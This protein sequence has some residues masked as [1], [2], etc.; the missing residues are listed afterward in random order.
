MD[1]EGQSSLLNA[2]EG[3]P[4]G[5]LPGVSFA[6]FSRSLSSGDIFAF[7]SDGVSEARNK[8]TEEYS[9]ERLQAVIAEFRQ[10]TAEG[11]LE[12]TEEDLNKF[13]GKAPQHD[14]ITLIIAKI[15]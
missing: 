13:M 14:D 1:R 3:I 4:I 6:N 12:K 2:E 15:D 8:K 7:Y 11:I 5:I 10:L 9:V